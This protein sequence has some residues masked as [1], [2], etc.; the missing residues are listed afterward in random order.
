MK[1][2]FNEMREPQAQYSV[3]RKKIEGYE[4]EPPK[5]RVSLED[6][7][8][9]IA[10]GTRRLEYHDG[11]VVDIQSATEIHGKICTNLTRLIGNCIY[12][13]DCDV[14][15]GDREVWVAPCNK[16]FYPD[17][18]VVCG[19]HDMKKMSKN[20]HATVNPSLVIEVLSEST[21][22]YDLTTKMRC[23]KKMKG[24][25]QIIFVAQIEKYVR[26]LTHS[27]EENAVFWK[28]AEYFED[29]EKIQIGDCTVLLQDIYRRVTL[30]SQGERATEA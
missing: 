2:E 25:K 23:Y 22:G 4:P 12:E 16:M 29:E 21:E 14:Y 7:L 8:E 24:L 11:E 3:A 30:D 1:D 27:E 26:V 18:I 17:V 6:Y 19:E 28:D 5:K 15:A 10:D 9:M 13:K 20:V